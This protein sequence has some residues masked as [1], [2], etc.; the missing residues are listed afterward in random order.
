[1]KNFE[2]ECMQARLDLAERQ[3]NIRLETLAK[4]EKLFGSNFQV[5]AE[6]VQ[7]H[8]LLSTITGKP[9]KYIEF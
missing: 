1:M 3:I 6:A 4:N 2:K 8:L 9:N 5:K 7:L